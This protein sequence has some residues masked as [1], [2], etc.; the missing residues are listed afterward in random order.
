[1]RG[2]K[3][4]T[5]QEKY[6]TNKSEIIQ[7]PYFAI[8]IKNQIRTIQNSGKSRGRL[9]SLRKIT[10][11]SRSNGYNFIQRVLIKIVLQTANK[12]SDSKI[13]C[14]CVCLE[15]IGYSR[16]SYNFLKTI[17][18]H[19][20]FLVILLEMEDVRLL[21]FVFSLNNREILFFVGIK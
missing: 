1:M 21:F 17:L 4:E 2:G 16:N 5:T 18:I 19:F 6:R 7:S 13:V 3:W 20:F 14:V 8:P 10:Q 15:D 11:I 12:I 9:F